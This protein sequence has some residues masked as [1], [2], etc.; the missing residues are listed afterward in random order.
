MSSYGYQEHRFS[1][2]Q[3]RITWSV[4]ILILA[5]I[6]AFAA[7]LLLEIP[8]GGNSLQ[9]VP[10]GL[11]IGWLAFSPVEFMRGFV[12]LPLTYLFLHSG[13]SHLFFNMLMLYFFGPDVERVLGTRQ[14]LSFYLLCG[15]LGVLANF[16]PILL[17]GSNANISVVGASG[18]TL[19]V[20]VAFALI[21]PDR[22]IF[23]FPIPIPL[24]ARAL[25][26]IVIVMNLMSALSYG[27]TTSVTTHFGGMFMGYL[28]MKYRPTWTAFRLKK[29]RPK[30]P[31][32]GDLDKL[33]E[34]IDNILK[35]SDRDRK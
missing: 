21:A 22:K 33:G 28:Y 3:D 2:G 16:V 18:A 9:G 26:I 34:E 32:K 14:F 20:L 29:R 17:F 11:A 19:G 1:I 25:V 31:R 12:W 30:T 27:S 5:N 7:Q 6:L 15:V 8:L 35:F 23:L 4:Q 13:L 10:G 24:N